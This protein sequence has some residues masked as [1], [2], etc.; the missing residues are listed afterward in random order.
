MPSYVLGGYCLNLLLAFIFGSPVF[1]NQECIRPGRICFLCFCHF[2]GHCSLT[3]GS[4]FNTRVL[5]FVHSRATSSTLRV[6][7]KTI[8]GTHPQDSPASAFLAHSPLPAAALTCSA[9]VGR[10]VGKGVERA[11]LETSLLLP[12]PAVQTGMR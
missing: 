2:S 8:V 11:S 7:I 9:M 3:Q 5:G 4:G 12:C 1:L 6:L 10:G